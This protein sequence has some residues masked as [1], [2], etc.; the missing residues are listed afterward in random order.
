MLNTDLQQHGQAENIF[1]AVSS[2]ADSL[3]AQIAARCA[4]NGYFPLALK[5]DT[6]RPFQDDWNVWTDWRAGDFDRAGLVGI[7]CGDGGLFAVD[8]DFDYADVVAALQWEFLDAPQRV[9]QRGFVALARWSDGRARTGHDLTW[10]HADGRKAPIQV[11]ARGLVAIFGRH[12]T[13]GL[14]YRWNGDNATLTTPLAALPTVE[15]MEA[16]LDRLDAVLSRFGFYRTKAVR[17]RA[18]APLANDTTILVDGEPFDLATLDAE[19]LDRIKRDGLDEF[20]RGLADLDRAGG[21]GRGNSSQELGVSV[22]KLFALGLADLDEA[23]DEIKRVTNDKNCADHSFPRGVAMSRGEAGWLQEIVGTPVRLARAKAAGAKPAAPLPAIPEAP[24]DLL[25]ALRDRAATLGASRKSKAV[26]KSRAD[27]ARLC[28]ALAAD[29]VISELESFEAGL[30]AKAY[31]QAANGKNPMFPAPDNKAI[32]KV[33]VET[34]RKGGNVRLTLAAGVAVLHPPTIIDGRALDQLAGTLSA[35]E[36]TFAAIAARLAF[37]RRDGA[38]I[39]VHRTPDGDDVIMSK[40]SVRDMI[41]NVLVTDGE[42]TEPAFDWW[43]R[44]PSRRTKRAVFKTHGD[45]GDDEYNFWRGFAVERR[46]GTDK[47]RKFARHLLD[48]VCRKNKAKFKYLVK[49]LA[50]AVQNPDRNPETVVVLK[51]VEEGGGKSTVSGAMRK[52]FGKSH[53]AVVK[54][55]EELLGQFNSHLEFASFVA[56]EETLF[57]GDRKQADTMRSA[58]TD[59]QLFVN[60]KFVKPYFAPNITHAILTTNHEHAVHAG[61]NARRWFVV[62]V[63]EAR[64]G[65]RGYFNALHDDMKDGGYEQLLNS[66][67]EVDLEGWHPRELVTTDELKEQMA[68]SADALD[69]WYAAGKEDGE[70][71]YFNELGGKVVVEFGKSWHTTTLFA[72]YLAYV[73]R[74]GGRADSRETFGRKLRRLLPGAHDPKTREAGKSKRAPGFALPDEPGTSPEAKRTAAIAEIRARLSEA[75]AACNTTVEEMLDDIAA[76]PPL[77]F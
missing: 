13:T 49:W 70:L 53:S 12:P 27:F 57:A 56:L 44:H 43:L 77:P 67:L 24:V 39:Y 29:G 20:A 73:R 63:D 21:T 36:D 61:V 68:M 72:S 3:F 35:N 7:R 46:R 14:L 71:S 8:V 15:S 69:Q 19:T 64:V 6:K 62:E 30:M 18:D 65:D 32:A 16:L 74:A 48:V 4:A 42:R 52:I 58:I 31:E 10:L 28:N 38:T 60:A 54:K 55:P 41:A 66:L 26:T 59:S 5:P 1:L 50:W 17:E 2:T 45:V 9:G 51:G 33:V 76:E 75:A 23:S 22:G 11:K 40:D 34:A 37:V 25:P 47:L